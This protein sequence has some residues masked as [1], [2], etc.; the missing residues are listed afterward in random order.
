[1]YRAKLF[2]VIDSIPGVKHID[3][4]GLVEN[5]IKMEVSSGEAPAHK[6]NNYVVFLVGKVII[7][8]ATFYLQKHR[9]HC[10][11]CNSDSVW[12]KNNKTNVWWSSWLRLDLELGQN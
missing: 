3:L 9:N 7:Q 11:D 4:D 6:L 1:M 2:A 5:E 8:D 10:D 12:I